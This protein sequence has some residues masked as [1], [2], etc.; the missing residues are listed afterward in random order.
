[1]G[2]APIQWW[3]KR[4]ARKRVRGPDDA[5]R[6]NSPSH[7]WGEVRS[8]DG[9]RVGGLLVTPNGY[10]LTA[11]SSV[12]I[13]ERVLRGAGVEGGY[14]SPAQLMGADFVRCLDGVQVVI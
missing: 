8:A 3:L 1:L 6:G 13:C 4:A 12:R 7:I 2:L 10:E 14:C 9:R 11:E 5:R